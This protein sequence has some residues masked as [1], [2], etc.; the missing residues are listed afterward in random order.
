MPKLLYCLLFAA[1]L[2]LLSGC[3]NDPEPPAEE[4]LRA[5]KT[6]VVS[7]RATQQQRTIAGLTEADIVTDLAFQVSGRLAEINVNVG[8]EISRGDV[9]ARLDDE[10]YQLNVRTAEGELNDARARLQEA[11]SAFEQRSPMYERGFISKSEFDTT[12][13]NRDS[14]R[15][16]V[17]V[18]NSRLALAQRDV[19]QSTL[20]SPLNGQVSEKY[21]EQF[22]EVTPG[23]RIVQ[24]SSDG[25]Q[26]VN[27]GIPENLGQHLNLGDPVNISFPTLDSRSVSGVISEIGSRVTSSSTFPVTV[28][29]DN[30]DP[31]I[32]PGMSAEITFAY[33]TQA[34]G[35]AFM[36]PMSAVLPT[37]A[38]NAG[39]V[40]AFNPESG[41]VEQRSINIIDVEDNE[42][43]V[44]GDIAE[45]EIVAIAGVS[46]LIDGMRVRLLDPQQAQ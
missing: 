26:K 14:A 23:Q 19:R 46:F 38:S 37:A 10:S 24:V 25:Q 13:A 40:F 39:T 6:I 35:Q 3:G 7:E 45:G 34:T 29:L 28:I 31:D 8:D 18:A 11:E 27:A 12:V 4:P 30:N 32:K 42:L 2:S 17:D 36:L 1:L 15:S 9:I 22:A 5:I 20:I 16:A 33:S 41:Q 21:E 44:T 43:Q